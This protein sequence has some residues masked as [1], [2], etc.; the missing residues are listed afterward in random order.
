[1]CD[2]REL[3]VVRTARTAKNLGKEFWGCVN[4]KVCF[5]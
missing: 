2:C 4:F 3:A 5:I 1:M